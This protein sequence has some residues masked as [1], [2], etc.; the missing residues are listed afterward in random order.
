M[1]SLCQ[2]RDG[3]VNK[4]KSERETTG[5]GGKSRA[6]EILHHVCLREYDG[7]DQDR[8]SN[9]PGPDRMV[10][11]LRLLQMQTATEIRS[12]T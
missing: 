10:Q 7:F 8:S 3:A 1:S 4:I 9:L 12:Q 11:P 6:V 5:H 2:R